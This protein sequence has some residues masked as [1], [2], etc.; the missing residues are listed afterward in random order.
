[1]YM[2][3][4]GTHNKSSWTIRSREVVMKNIFT[5]T[6]RSVYLSSL[7]IP[8]FNLGEPR[9]SSKISAKSDSSFEFTSLGRGDG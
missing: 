4:F 7:L 5:D 8:E 6:Q 9:T 3:E 1:M 2:V